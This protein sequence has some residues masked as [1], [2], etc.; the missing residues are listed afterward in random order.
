M[1]HAEHSIIL[2]QLSVLTWSHPPALRE[3]MGNLSMR[4]C[5]R[6]MLQIKIGICSGLMRHL[7]LMQFS[8]SITRTPTK[9]FKRFTILLDTNNLLLPKSKM[10]RKFPALP[11][12]AGGPWHVTLNR[13]EPD[14]EFKAAI[15]IFSFAF[16][17]FSLNFYIWNKFC[18]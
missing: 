9:I 13:I 10:A 15:Y 16:S 2:H 4:K 18:K 8:F 7:A 14:T 1:H 12:T 17:V 6:F 5:C 3:G 11:N